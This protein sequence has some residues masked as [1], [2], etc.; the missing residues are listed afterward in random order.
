MG[1]LQQAAQDGN[2]REV[3]E[4]LE[5]NLAQIDEKSHT[6]W[7]TLHFAAF[8]GNER[9]AAQLL[10][11]RPAMLSAIESTEG[12]L[13]LHV[14]ARAGRMRMVTLLL[15][16][17]PKAID[18]TDRKGRTPMLVAGDYGQDQVVELLLALKP[19]LISG[20]DST[21]NTVLHSL[22]R[23]RGWEPPSKASITGV[24]SM[25]PEAL[26]VKNAEG[27]TPFHVALGVR[28]KWATE[29]LQSKLSLD[30]LVAVYADCQVPQER[31]RP[32]VAEQCE[33]F[34]FGLLSRD[35]VG[36]VY[37][38]LGFER[39]KRVKRGA[40]EADALCGVAPNKKRRARK[41]KEEATTTTPPRKKRTPKEPAAP[42]QQKRS[43]KVSS[44]K[45]QCTA[46][47]QCNLFL[48]SAAAANVVAFAAGFGG[49]K[50]EN[51]ALENPLNSMMM[52]MLLLQQQERNAQ[53]I[54]SRDSCGDSSKSF[55]VMFSNN[56]H[57]N[58][59]N[60]LCD[61]QLFPLLPPL[62]N[63]FP[64]DFPTAQQ[65]STPPLLLNVPSLLPPLWNA[66]S[67]LPP[68]FP[69]LT[70]SSSLPPS[71]ILNN[72]P[73][74]LPPLPFLNNDVQFPLSSPPVFS[75][76]D[77]STHFESSDALWALCPNPTTLPE[78]LIPEFDW[79][80]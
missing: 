10:T 52:R 29:V 73:S 4:L 60:L 80:C 51:A 22:V 53:M 58:S 8:G 17:D 39:I 59:N 65:P 24:W 37:E 42:K 70:P 40:I 44:T 19:G 38:Y 74:L 78:G 2:E 64:M 14:A 26:Q 9:I 79:I 75:S 49:L 16:H 76:G 11:H 72:V 3:A 61:G 6:L 77:V 41:P 15:C 31:A 46:D 57:S 54:V 56:N 18:T 68:L 33:E 55:G 35:V 7:N 12:W 36:T 32:L 5:K 47:P 50:T 45:R 1:Y 62:S 28:N 23:Y 48:D 34:L 66:P 67:S 69:P 30:Q 63:G 43:P 21:G 25:D 20:R 27:Q 71:F 13:P